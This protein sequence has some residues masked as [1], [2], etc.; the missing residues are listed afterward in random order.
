[1]PIYEFNCN[2]CGEEFEEI[3]GMSDKE[4]PP[5]PKCGG[6]DTERM[7]SSFSSRLGGSSAGVSCGPS[8]GFS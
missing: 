7:M 8:K 3:V 4:T 5:C 6:K 2:K 1:M